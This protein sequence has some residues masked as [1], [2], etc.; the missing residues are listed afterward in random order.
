[1]NILEDMVRHIQS[2]N[3]FLND[4]YLSEKSYTQLLRLC[5]PNYRETYAKNLYF[6]GRITEKALH[7]FTR[8]PK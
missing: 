2:I 5:H 6:E 4:E 1:M 7:T 3:K 8:N